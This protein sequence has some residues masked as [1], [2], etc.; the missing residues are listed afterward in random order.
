MHTGTGRVVELMLEDGCRT[1][2]LACPE[3]LVPAPG[4]YLLAGSSPDSLL[5]AALFFTESV[6]Q[7]FIGPA[8]DSWKPGDLLY[9][10]GPL[11]HGFS[12][13][14]SARRVG[15]VAF[16]GPPA[17]LRGLIRPA[18]GQGASVV[19]LCD[20]SAD[21]LPDEVEVQPLS[22]L[23]E[24]LDWADFTALDVGRENLHEL[25][26]GIGKQTPLHGAQ[27]L[28]RAPMPCGGLGECGVCA[29][30][31]GSEWRLVCRDGPVFDLRQI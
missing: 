18:L 7:G 4:Q 9:L 24:I 21:R 25:K 29:L 22:T 11:G 30:T 26:G 12:L 13:P 1:A 31:A 23:N 27:I 16:D 28:V 20:S 3:S 6:P 10:R 8:P 5:P 17:R 15:L 2:W 14:P 19:L